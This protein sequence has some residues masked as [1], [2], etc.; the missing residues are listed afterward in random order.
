MTDPGRIRL[1]N[2]TPHTITVDAPGRPVVLEPESG[3]VRLPD[4]PV[5]QGTLTTDDGPVRLTTVQRRQSAV[6]LPPPE[7][8]VRYVVSRV[9]AAALDRDDVVF[10]LGE[11]RDG[12]GRIVAVQGLGTFRE[13]S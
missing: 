5:A 2:L 10:P 11:R 13:H 12:E 6:G 3:P 1:R 8:N 4:E 7:H 9:A